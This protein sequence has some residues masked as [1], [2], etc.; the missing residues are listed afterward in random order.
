MR[1][2]EKLHLIGVWVAQIKQQRGDTEYTDG[3]RHSIDIAYTLLKAVRD[4]PSVGQ[5]P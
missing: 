5:I 2:T 1:V 4:V 3:E